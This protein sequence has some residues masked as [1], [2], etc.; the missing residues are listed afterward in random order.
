[1]TGFASEATTGSVNFS[2]KVVPS[3][4]TISSDSLN[5]IVDLEQAQTG[6]MRAKGQGGKTRFF[7]ID[8]ENC[9]EASLADIT[10]EDTERAR[11]TEDPGKFLVNVGSARGVAIDIH[12]LNL[13]T[14]SDTSETLDFSGTSVVI[15]LTKV[16][17]GKMYSK[18]SAKMVR[19]ANATVTAGN[20][21]SQIKYQVSYK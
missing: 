13:E 1:M 21:S 6:Q 3:T 10:L 8:L 18:F 9:P 12:Y 2:G 4:C 20:V 16:V 19:I 17:N 7:N 11:M 14:K 15:P 5:Q